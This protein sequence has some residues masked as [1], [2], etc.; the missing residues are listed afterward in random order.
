MTGSNAYD[1]M[2]SQVAGA[3]ESN[4]ETGGIV[5][6][7]SSIWEVHQP[8]KHYAFT[9]MAAARG[10]CD[11]AAMAKKGGKSADVTH[12]AMLWQKVNA[13]VQPSFLDPQMGL[14]GS[15]EGLPGQKTYHCST[16]E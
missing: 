12:Y 2:Q 9:T 14:A 1:V 7:D 3:L 11:M 5:R 13:G 15:I 10:F 16:P 8:G 6:A 4:L